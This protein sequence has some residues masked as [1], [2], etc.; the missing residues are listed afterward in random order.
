[1]AVL[2][3]CYVSFT[4]G[5]QDGYNI[6]EVLECSDIYAWQ[7]LHK[8]QSTSDRDMPPLIKRLLCDSY[9]SL[10]QHPLLVMYK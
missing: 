3:N 1:M 2:H 7:D 6:P 8:V 10:Y 5:G 4:A 9:I